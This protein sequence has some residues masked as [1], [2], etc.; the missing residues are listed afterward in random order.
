MLDQ[1]ISMT[2]SNTVVTFSSV[3]NT[4]KRMLGIMI[5][6][7]RS[8]CLGPTDLGMRASNVASSATLKRSAI[9][10]TH[11]ALEDAKKVFGAVRITVSYSTLVRTVC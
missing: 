4:S 1:M 3:S 6:K 10:G 9:D 7:L 5:R 8:L 2:S 11:R